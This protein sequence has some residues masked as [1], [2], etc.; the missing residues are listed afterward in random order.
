MASTPV[1]PPA[2]IFWI[3]PGDWNRYVSLCIDR[4]TLPTTYEKWLY[5][6]EKAAKRLT[7]QGWEIIRV[8][9]DLDEFS[10]WCRLKRLDINSD[11]RTEYANEVAAAQVRARDHTKH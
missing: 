11:A 10:A 4:E 8:Y 6:A 5:R 7:Q 2:G 1:G 3:K 9:V